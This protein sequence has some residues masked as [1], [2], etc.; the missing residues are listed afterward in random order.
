MRLR[1]TRA[2]GSLSSMLG[3]LFTARSAQRP[4]PASSLSGV[5]RFEERKMLA[6]SIGAITTPAVGS[7]DVDLATDLVLSFNEPVVKGQGNIY[8]V[9]QATGQAGTWVDVRDAAVTINGA[10]VS[11][12][13]PV[14]LVPDNTY[15]IHIDPG[16]FL[17]S[18]TTPTAGA[19]LLTQNFE[20]VN[21][22][23]FIN[24]TDGDGTDFSTTGQ[25][26]FTF[27]TTLDPTKGIDE[28]RG[29]SYAGEDSW[30]AADGQSRD[31]FT[32][33]EGT[34]MI[35]DSDEY[36]DG[37]AAETPWVG[38]SYTKPVDLTGVAA[39]SVTLEFDSSFRHE[40]AQL[41]TVEVSF[42]GGGS[43]TELLRLDGTNTS[44]SGDPLQSASINERLVSGTTTGVGGDGKGGAAFAA[45]SN[46]DSGTMQFRFYSEGDNDWWWA[47]D[48]ILITAT[49]SAFPSMG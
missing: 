40:A 31:Q 14:D 37:N 24:E 19:T 33:G 44:G 12:D 39:N 27:D 36:D 48:N 22:E 2:N 26:G 10:D 8:V 45:V 32:L 4:R 6:L 35:A 28:W 47:I 13:L 41:G 38:Y 25:F 23:P 9:E 46:P 20:F 5:E 15:S 16:A 18:S 29:W 11:I 49:S 21:L 43:W 1:R 30:L 34:L 7:T 42:D 17:D 3:E